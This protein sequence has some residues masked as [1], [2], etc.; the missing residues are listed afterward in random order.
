MG[1]WVGVVGGVGG[2]VYVQGEGVHTSICAPDWEK[3]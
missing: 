1:G 3:T 2:W